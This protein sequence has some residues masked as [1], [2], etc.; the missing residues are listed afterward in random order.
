[1]FWIEQHDTLMCREILAVDSFTVKK[2][3]TVQRGSKW[4]VIVEHLM[5]I[6]TTTFKVDTRAARD[7]MI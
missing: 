3:G 1:M 5:A 4:K 2:K 7:R 6:E